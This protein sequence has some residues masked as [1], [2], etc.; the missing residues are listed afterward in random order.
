ETAQ[1][2]LEGGRRGARFGLDG[3]GPARL[4]AEA[5]RGPREG[6]RDPGRGARRPGRGELDAGASPARPARD[7]APRLRDLGPFPPRG[8]A[9]AGASFPRDARPALR[10]RARQLR[11]CVLL[12]DRAARAGRA[13]GAGTEGVD[14]RAVL[15]GD[16]PRITR[17]E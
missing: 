10:G 4:R 12:G 5:R 16:T 9:P 3:G 11:S 17:R 6:G 8:K 7:G 13:A 1:G 15:W 2:A 14:A